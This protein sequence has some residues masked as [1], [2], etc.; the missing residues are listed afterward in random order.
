[1]VVLCDDSVAQA[2]DP[3]GIG[4][5]VLFVSDHHHGPALGMQTCKRRHHVHARFGVEVSGGF[6]SEDQGR[7][8]DDGA[9]NGDSLLL[10]TGHLVGK[11]AHPIFQPDRFERAFGSMA[12]LLAGTPA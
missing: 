11:V 10:A 7:I 12:P 3:S 2:D 4:R 9:G 6:V 8:G 1:M 5:D